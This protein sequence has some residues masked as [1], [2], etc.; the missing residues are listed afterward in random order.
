MI[1]VVYILGGLAPDNDQPMPPETR[2]AVQDNWR[3]IEE[4]LGTEFNHDFWT[5]C[6]PRRDTYK[7]CRAVVA[8]AA[9]G[10]GEQMIEAIQRGYY[11]RAMNPSEPETL[12]RFAGEVGLDVERFGRDLLSE[13][14]ETEFRRQLN[15]RRH[16]GVR[17]FPSLMLAHDGRISHIS[18]DHKDYRVS[19]GN[20]QALLQN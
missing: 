5:Q 11:L 1:Q 12:V 16:L 7:A 19:L 20:I 8:A 6:Q 10:A 15:H 13:E 3:R 14:T 2:R 4:M 18:H 9:Q 17:T